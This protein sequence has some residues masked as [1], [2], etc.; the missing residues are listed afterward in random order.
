MIKTLVALAFVFA[1]VA[2]AQTTVVYKSGTEGYHTFRIPSV[3]ATPKGTLLAFAE[4]RLK[5]SS[6]NGDIDTVLKRST[7]GG[8]T[9]EKMQLIHDAGPDCIGNPCA[10]VDRKTGRV[11]LLL[12]KKPGANSTSDNKRGGGKGPMEMFATYSD[13]DGVTWAKLA[14][15]T[16]QAK[17]PEWT[18][19]VPGPGVGIQTASGRLVV[20]CN[21]RVKGERDD[22]ASVAHVMYSDDGGQSWKI[23][24]EMDRHTNESQIV[25]RA[26]GSLMFNARSHAGKN[27][28]AIATSADGGL[29]FGKTTLDDGLLDPT[30]QASVVRLPDVDG[31][32]KGR[33]L[34]ANNNSAK[35]E[36]MTVRLST[37]GGASWPKTLLLHEGPSAYSCLVALPGDRAG[38]L[39]E[40]GKYEQIVFTRF[41]VAELK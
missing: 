31:Q 14:D 15:V 19:I 24:G 28:R 17:K 27:R 13:D 34:F 11:W 36:K 35:R 6:D 18:W 22:K 9:W 3:V 33:L 4:A 23:G 30:C 38:C 7:D 37:D 1:G 29:T 16:P 40:T 10:V 39:Y 21:H 26:D 25:E 12:M 5:S 8:A 32:P 2:R 20:P 41:G